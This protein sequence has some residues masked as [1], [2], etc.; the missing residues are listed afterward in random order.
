MPGQPGVYAV[1]QTIKAHATV[2]RK[3]LRAEG[4][5]KLDVRVHEQHDIV[6]ARRRREELD[7]LLLYPATHWHKRPAQIE[8]EV[9]ERHPHEAGGQQLVATLH[10]SSRAGQASEQM[11]V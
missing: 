6:S 2:P 5:D 8:H 3:R 10:M 9:S 1:W 4:T 7:D 11:N